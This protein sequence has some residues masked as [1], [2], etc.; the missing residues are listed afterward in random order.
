MS[1]LGKVS[2]D[3]YGY[4]IRLERVYNHPVSKVWDALTDPAKMTLWFTDVEWDFRP[5][6]D[7]TFTFQ[8]PDRTKSYGSITAIEPEKLLEF[9][10]HNDDGHPEE[11]MRLELTNLG[12]STRLIMEYTRVRES[13]GANVLTGWHVVFDDFEDFLNGRTEFGNFGVGEFSEEDKALKKKYE[14]LIEQLNK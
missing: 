13:Y 12:D 4:G 11:L 2:K 6:G 7:I 14:T 1:E 9:W 5:G 10:W 8:D 3:G